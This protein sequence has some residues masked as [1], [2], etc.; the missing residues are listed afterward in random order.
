MSSMQYEY[1][2][3]VFQ[4]KIKDSKAFEFNLP[5]SIAPR[6]IEGLKYIII[7]GLICSK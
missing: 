6:F 2:A 7:K 5:L 1:A 3:L 4:K